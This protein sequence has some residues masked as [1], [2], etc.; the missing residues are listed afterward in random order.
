[1]GKPV[2]LYGFPA[3]LKASYMKRIPKKEGSDAIFT[4]GCDLLMLHVGDIVGGSMR[5]LDYDEMIAAYKRE[6]MDPTSYY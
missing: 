6:G 5:I 2:F 1:F 4:V 3:E